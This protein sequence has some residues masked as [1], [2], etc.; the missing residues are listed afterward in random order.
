MWVSKKKRERERQK[1]KNNHALDAQVYPL[2]RAEENLAGC[3]CCATVDQQRPAH[4]DG[5]KGPRPRAAIAQEHHGSRAESALV[6]RLRS[7]VNVT[8]VCFL[9]RIGN[10]F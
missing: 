5:A 3:D 9:D 2:P 6:D 10:F 1:R 7:R 4:T 8:A